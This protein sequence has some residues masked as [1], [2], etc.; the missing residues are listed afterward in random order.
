MV[1]MRNDSQ[2]RR[3]MKKVQEALSSIEASVEVELVYDCPVEWRDMR[4]MRSHGDGD[5]VRHCEKCGS[6][7]YDLCQTPKRSIISLVRSSGG[8]LCGQVKARADGLVVFGSCSADRNAR[9]MRG[10]IVV[11]TR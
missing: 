1:L 8:E 6:R 7:V 9:P 11:R 10:R 2:G 3:T 4:P 5:T